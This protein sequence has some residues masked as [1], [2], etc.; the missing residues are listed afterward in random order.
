MTPRAGGD[1]E[2]SST[3]QLVGLAERLGALAD[4]VGE[5]GGAA[6]EQAKA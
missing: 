1:G 2:G 3:E 4:S 5:A 6:A